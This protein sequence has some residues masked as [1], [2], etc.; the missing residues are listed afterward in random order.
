MITRKYFQADGTYYQFVKDGDYCYIYQRNDL[1][2]IISAS[3]F[4]KYVTRIKYELMND[5]INVKFRSYRLIDE[6]QMDSV[7]R[8]HIV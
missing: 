1:N 8:N 4:W 3:R 2:L 5:F 7:I 6:K